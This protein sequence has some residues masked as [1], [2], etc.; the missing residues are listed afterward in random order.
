M[1][2]V[3]VGCLIFGCAQLHFKV[4]LSDRQQNIQDLKKEAKMH[5]KAEE[6]CRFDGNYV[7]F[8]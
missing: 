2:T 5:H 7:D 4:Q 3:S 8:N 1:F 6:H